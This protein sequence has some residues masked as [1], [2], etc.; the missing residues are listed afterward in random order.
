M[1]DDATRIAVEVLGRALA[2]LR[3]A[4]AEPAENP[5]AI[6]GTIQRFE[7]VIEPYWKALRR[8]LAADG[9]ATATPRESLQA[10]FAA[11]WLDNETLW[12]QLLRDRNETSH[13]YNEATAR[14]I[15]ANVRAALPEL[16]RTYEKLRG[17]IGERRRE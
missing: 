10:A 6:D 9:I 15:Y 4:A 14:R 11:G 3:E 5:L 16:E 7:F 12:L 8:L 2:R 17:R 1:A 13:T